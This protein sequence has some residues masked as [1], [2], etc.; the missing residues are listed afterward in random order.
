[1]HVLRFSAP[2]AFLVVDC[3]TLALTLLRHHAVLADVEFGAILGM[4]VSRVRQN[5]AG[6]TGDVTVRAN[7]A[8][9]ENVAFDVLAKA[10]GVCR[11]DAGR[12]L[13][14]VDQA[15]WTGHHL[16]YP[17]D[18]VD[19]AVARGR[20]LVREVAVRAGTAF[21]SMWL[22]CNRSCN[23]YYSCLAFADVRERIVNRV[24]YNM[25]R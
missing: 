12:H 2:E 13:R 10:N 6:W 22:L 15:R 21:A 25:Q 24:S 9:I 23:C 5:P 20:V 11:P 4:R 17:V 3:A 1:M 7:E 8:V 16:R 18:A 19:E 14:L